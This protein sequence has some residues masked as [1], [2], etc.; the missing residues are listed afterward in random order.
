MLLYMGLGE[1]EYLLFFVLKQH[2]C[3]ASEARGKGWVLVAT[4]VGPP[5]SMYKCACF[6]HNLHEHVVYRGDCPKSCEALWR[7]ATF[8]HAI[9]LNYFN[10]KKRF[11][12][13]LIAILLTVS[14]HIFAQEHLSL[15]APTTQRAFKN[16]LLAQL[17]AYALY[18]LDAQALHRFAQ[19]QQGRPFGLHLRFGKEHDWDMELMPAK[20]HDGDFKFV[21]SNGEVVEVDRNITYKGYLK[22]NPTIKV[23]MTIGAHY[24]FGRIQDAEEHVFELLEKT[25]QHTAHSLAVVYA[26]AAVP[27]KSPGC[28][29]LTEVTPPTTLQR[30]VP[31]AHPNAVANSAEASLLPVTYC[32]RLAIVLDWQGLA[33][34]GSVSNF[35]DEIQTIVNI[36][37]GFYDDEFGV[38]YVLN[39]VRFISASPNPWQDVSAGQHSTLVA[40][41][42]QWAY[43]NLSPTNYNCALLYT[44]LNLNGIGYAYF[45]HMCPGDNARYGEIDYHYNQTISHRAKLTTH[46][47]GHL[48]DARHASPSDPIYIMNAT[49][50]DR[51]IIWDNAAFDVITTGVNTRFNSC[52]PSCSNL[53]VNWASPQ[54]GQIFQNFDPIAL[55]VAATADVPISKVE[56]YVNNVLIATDNS[57]PYGTSWT[58]PGYANYNLKAI[59][60]DNTNTQSAK[61]ISISVKD[62]T[63]TEVSAW[64]RANSDDAEQN[65]STGAMSLSST[66][67]ELI[68]DGT[69][70]QQV[71]IRFK[72]VNVP[73]GANITTAYIQFATDE[74]GSGAVSLNIYGQDHGNPPTFTTATNNISSRIKTNATVAWS[75]AA[76]PTLT[77]AGS[78][79]RTPN[80]STIVQSLVSRPDWA[81]NN[82]MAFVVTGTGTRIAYAREGDTTKAP[83][84]HI[85]YTL[86]PLP[87]A[88]FAAN[89]IVIAPGST[90]QFTSNATGDNL[91]HQWTFEGGTPATSTAANP[92][93]TFSTLGS[94]DVSLSVSNAYGSHTATKADYI[95][96]DQVCAG[97]GSVSTANNYITNVAIGAINKASGKS[98]YAYYTALS[99]SV[100][101]GSAYPITVTLQNAT[102]S[103]AVYVWADWNG[104]KLLENSESIPMSVPN[105]AYQCNGTVAVPLAAVTGSVRLRVRSTNDA[106]GATPCD[107]YTGEVE[108]YTLNIT[109]PTPPAAP[110]NLSSSSVTNSSANLSWATVAGASGYNLQ[111]RPIGGSWALFNPTTN[112]L[113]INALT[114]G[115][116]YEWQVETYNAIGSSGYSTPAFFTTCYTNCT[117]LA[118]SWGSPSNG[119]VFYTI[120]PITLNASAGGDGGVAQVMFFANN[121]LVGM[122]D[123]APYSVNWTPPAY[124]IYLLNAVCTSNLGQATSTQINVTVQDPSTSSLTAQVNAGSDDAEQNISGGSMYLTSSDLELI[125]DGSTLQQ[126]GMRFKN[127]GIPRGSTIVQAYIQFTADVA[128][129]TATSL[130]IYAENHGNPGTFTTGTNNISNRT[131]TTTS[132]PWT[133]AA[134]NT[135]GEEGANQRTPDLSGLVQTL[136]GRSDWNTNNAMV[137][138]VTGSGHRA[139]KSYEGSATKAPKLYITYIPNNTP[140]ADFTADKTTISP[141]GTVQFTSTSGGTA[142]AYLWTFEGGTPATSTAA[143]P[144]VTY[145][146]PGTYSTT[147]TV[148]NGTG[149]NTLV[150]TGYISV[151]YCPATARAGTGDDYIVKVSVGGVENVSGKTV[152]T[153][154]PSTLRQVAKSS[155][156]VLKATLNA[157]F[158]LDNMYV[159]ADW[160][161]NRV[162]ET[163]E[164]VA[165]SGFN[166]AY[167]STGTLTVPANATNGN[168]RLRVRC[169]YGTDGPQPCGV[170]WGEVE[171]YVLEVVEAGALGAPEGLTASDL[172]TQS[173]TLSW[174]A[175]PGATAYQGQIRPLGG[176]WSAFTSTTLSYHAQALTADTDYEWQVRATNANTTGNYAAVTN[177][178]TSVAAGYCT[179]SG[180]NASYE[181]I[182]KVDVGAF[183]KASGAAGYSNFTGNTIPMTVGSNYTLSLTPGFSGSSYN[184]YWKIW[185]DLAGDG[186]FD[187]EDLLFDAGAL[188]NGA[189]TGTIAIPAG[190]APITTRMRVSMRYSGAATAC[191]VFSYGEVEDYTVQI[192]EGQGVAYCDASVAGILTYYYIKKVTLNTINTNNT[193]GN[194][195]TG[196][197]DYTSTA[198]TLVAGASYPITMH[199]YPEWSGNSGKV[200]ID[201]NAD[202]DFTDANEQVLS[203]SGSGPTY[204]AT[205]T[206]PANAVHGPTRMRVRLAH[207]QTVAPCGLHDYG[208]IED[209]TVSIVPT[210][211]APQG[212]GMERTT[213]ATDMDTLDVRLFP[214]PASGICTLSL[215]G[216]G[217]AQVRVVGV[218]GR[219]VQAMTATQGTQRLDLRGLLP[220]VYFVHVSDRAREIVERLVVK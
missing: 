147:L 168:I 192:A 169:L 47:L 183:S 125:A 34:A 48:W 204:S 216:L 86:G 111:L 53:T 3:S 28:G 64:V 150:K 59:A 121:T 103:D 114:P 95:A 118:V 181:W 141:S 69:T 215:V 139:A 148:S 153:Y 26:N 8:A 188:S 46:E 72:N 190:T 107:D 198:T 217:E 142:L 80:L 185:V 83:V 51:N 27:N 23:R 66:D 110:T 67:L 191:S 29:H 101:K 126:V 202:G 32:P 7:D 187:P 81:A 20:V 18:D 157:A 35:N 31:E 177:F 39:D 65:S 24:I 54:N 127:I 11:L 82:A 171:D 102:G 74:T 154:Y 37:N 73:A 50:Y 30:P 193:L 17:P 210:A 25:P 44:G 214:N 21:G 78:A 212:A 99:T 146:T 104:N 131:K 96:V 152:Y 156:Y 140:I 144:L 43:P 176:A 117:P 58:P 112:T 203:G 79:Q 1:A 85:A 6:A 186:N 120:S 172:T 93:V 71:G 10:M 159:W 128:S 218:D 109:V 40:N 163:G 88:D 9:Q 22:N 124:G 209:Y 75:P 87:T 91:N 122:D 199:F 149:S 220:G 123:S 19:R 166:T 41:F 89:E 167:E 98:R 206:V 100:E 45:G 130:Q 205:L 38:N 129:S 151:D 56:F 170:Y 196:Y 200:Y 94:F 201:W 197:S 68:A 115:T 105:G 62:P 90:V 173:A 52:L 55:S 97:T 133:P 155:S 184:E 178:S 14:K 213:T 175:V 182:A 219:T 162:F 13:G 174:A 42:S 63:V 137:F 108:D 70:Q 180:N 138:M 136:V 106:A 77:E 12:F 36:I 143:N 15:D 158:S 179:S 76:W 61:Q 116:P 145:N 160:N 4:K 113:N 161:N 132:V 195:V 164:L 92:S 135:A 5:R 49:I 189:V 134:W 208:E 207:Y 16:D 84:L 211:N 165:M 57:S 194:T 33:K 60:F 2:K 119:Q